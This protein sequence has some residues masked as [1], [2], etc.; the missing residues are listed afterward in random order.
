[1]NAAESELSQLHAAT[2]LAITQFNLGKKCPC[3]ANRIVLLLQ[4]LV[5]H[6]DLPLTETS[7]SLYLNLIDHWLKVRN[8]LKKKNV[9]SV[10]I[11]TVYH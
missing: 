8:E 1:M 10:K 3:L 7:K 11:A 9:Q 4:Y 5:T 6:P 2:C